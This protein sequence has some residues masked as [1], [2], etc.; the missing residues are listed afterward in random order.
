[1]PGEIGDQVSGA[2]I[3]PRGVGTLGVL[4]EFGIEREKMGVLYNLDPLTAMSL[5]YGGEKNGIYQG[6]FIKNKK[7]RGL[8]LPSALKDFLENYGYMD[9]NRNKASFQ[10]FHPD[11]I[12]EV[13]LQVNTGEMSVMVVGVFQDYLVGILPDTRELQVTFGIQGDDGTE[14]NPANLTFSG[15][16]VTMLVSLLFRND[17]HSIF[18]ESYRIYMQIEKYGAKRT[19]ILPGTGC[20]QHF[21]LN[22]HEES[23][24]FFVAEFEK[25]G[26]EITSLHVVPKKVFTLDELEELF[27]KEF[28]E[29][30]LN[31]DFV[32]ALAIQSELIKRLED[33]KSLELAGHYKLAARCCW[34]LGR[35]DDAASWYEKGLPIIENNIERAPEQAADYYHAMGNFYADR[36]LYGGS[37]Q[38]YEKELDIL[39]RFFPED[40]YKMG[41]VYQ[42]QASFLVKSE[43]DI[44][45]AIELYNKA[46]DEFQKKPK[47]CKYDIA[48][49]QQLRGRQNGRRRSALSV[50]QRWIDG[51]VFY[52]KDAKFGLGRDRGCR[53]C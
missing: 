7:R 26:V 41:M 28:Y 25:H 48:R 53:S 40:V 33:A 27:N 14:W 18:Q 31:C 17:D 32:H 20:P 19:E 47:D 36:K 29:N 13:C 24:M 12:S 44:D 8:I 23:G 15:M 11:D 39:Q 42:A 30:S 49:T 5:F 37:E 3:S 9:V 50:Y 22:F 43:G 1:M 45:R 16:L 2:V 4:A 52:R 51:C 10:L 35:L 34:A 6:D 38:F 21:S 46:L